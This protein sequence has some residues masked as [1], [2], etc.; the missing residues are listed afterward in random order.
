MI[1]FSILKDFGAFFNP[2]TKRG[3][4]RLIIVVIVAVVAV[5][6]FAADENVS[7]V[8]VSDTKPQVTL[9][10]AA[11]IDDSTVLSLIGTVAAVNQATIRPEVPGTV[12]RVHARL[13]QQVTAGS[14]I[15]ELENA[16]QRAALLQAEGAYEAAVAAA[17]VSDVSVDNARTSL[18]AAQNGAL[19]TYRNAYTTVSSVLYNYVDT[20]YTDPN[21]TLP[22]V[23]IEG[24][25]QTPYLNNTRV[26]LQTSLP[27]WQRRTTT[28]SVDDNLSLALSDAATRTNAMLQLVDTII[29]RLQADPAQYENTQYATL[30]ATLLSQR[31]ALTST[32]AQ[33]D[34]AETGVSQATDALAQA[35]FAGTN[36]DLSAANAQIKQAAGALAAARANYNKT[37]I[38]TPIG[39]SIN[40]IDV[41]IGDFVSSQNELATV[42][43][44]GSLE[45]T[46]FVGEN[47][48]TFLNIGESVRIAGTYD[49]VVTTIAP[50]LNPTTKKYEVKIAT[51]ATEIANGDTVRISVTRTDA[52]EVDVTQPITVPL[53]AVKF[54]ADNGTIFTVSA[55]STL[56]AV[57]VVLGPVVGAQVTIIE[58]L[59]WETEF[60]LDAR[61]LVAGQE[62]TITP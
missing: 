48:K 46:T 5:R 59:D 12:T 9:R 55:D 15:V 42:A 14:I 60:V 62:V 30:S 10:T 29:A 6:F 13:G 23:R 54:T 38:R 21:S 27:E 44:N 2:R 39:G 37:I 16:T 8:V 31:A 50:A 51:D 7:E 11:T 18:R 1:F 3:L 35:Q 58:G 43:N 47:D 49:G 52:E 22:G 61:G 57:P 26:S 20:I 19:N 24:A 40:A 36:Q 53:S 28:I 32:L 45:I 56:V 4:F 34:A 25:N 17:A 33:L 41:H